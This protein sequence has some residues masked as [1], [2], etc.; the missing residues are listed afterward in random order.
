MNK[1]LDFVTFLDFELNGELGLRNFFFVVVGRGFGNTCR[2]IIVDFLEILEVFGFE[3]CRIND[4]NIM[5]FK[6]THN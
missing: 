1:P 3:L 4:L 5:K 2:S 6:V